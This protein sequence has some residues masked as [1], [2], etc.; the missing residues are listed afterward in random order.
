MTDRLHELMKELITSGRRFTL[1]EAQVIVDKIY[2]DHCI[3]TTDRIHNTFFHEICPLLTIA[4][5]V[6]GAAT[7]IAFTGD[8]SGFDGMVF[9]EAM[10]KPQKVELTTAIDGRNDALIMELKKKRGSAPAFQK[11]QATGNKKN[12]EFGENK[13]RAIK[14]N[15]YDQTV[16][17][18]LLKGALARKIRK[19]KKNQNYRDA[20]LGIVFDDQIMPLEAEKKQKRFDPI[21]KQLLGNKLAQYAP[22]SRVFCVG[23]SRKYVFDSHQL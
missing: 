23:I 6:D 12:R 8:V 20:W 17:L 3:D 18:P 5:S 22:F 14:S 1:T 21:C 9:H 7:E 15:G 4:K 13:L 10:G 11:I 2:D 16:L 19:S